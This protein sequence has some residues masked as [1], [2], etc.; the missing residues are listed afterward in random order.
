MWAIFPIFSSLNTLRQ[1]ANF[2][3]LRNTNYCCPGVVFVLL[4]VGNYN[5][6]QPF[7]LHQRVIH[8]VCIHCLK[9]LCTWLI[10]RTDSR[11][12]RLQRLQNET[13]RK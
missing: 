13:T 9:Y 4:K 1:V 7:E 12:R 11:P 3:Q 8:A 10:Q 2:P 6:T 5:V